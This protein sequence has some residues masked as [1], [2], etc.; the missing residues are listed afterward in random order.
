MS[1]DTRYITGVTIIVKN[2]EC[3]D[4]F[5]LLK[6]VSTFMVTYKLNTKLYS[7]NKLYEI[8]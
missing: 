3:N 6:A 1:L 4:F 5:F 7:C 8:T 2:I